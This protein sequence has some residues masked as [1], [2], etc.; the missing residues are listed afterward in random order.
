LCRLKADKIIL[1]CRN[2]ERGENAV[3]Q[4]HE[5]EKKH[6]VEYMQL[7]LDDLSSVKRFADE[8]KAKYNKLDVLVNNAGIMAL[9]VKQT[10]A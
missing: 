10:T 2:K 7:D 9:P 3:K 5:L 8:F 6:N 4:I 1:A